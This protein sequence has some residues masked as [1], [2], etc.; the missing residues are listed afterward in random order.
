MTAR[1]QYGNLMLRKR[2]KGPD[3]W[4]FRWMEN[5]K[6]KS[7]LIGTIE[8]YPTRADAERAI[9]YLRIK[10]NAQSAQSEFH[11]VTVGGLLD[12]Y[13]E[14]EMPARAYSTAQTYRMYINRYV[15]PVWGAVTLDKIKPVPVEHWLRSLTSLSDRS[16][17][18]IRNIFHLVFQCALRWELAQTNPI[19]LVRQGGK[20]R[21]TP[22]VLTP[23]E[24]GTLLARLAAPYNSMVLFCAGLGLRISEVMGLKWGDVDWE[25]LSVK[26]RR[27]IVA[28]RETPLKTE[29]SRKPLPLDPDL[30]TE[31]L[32][33]RAKTNH[34]SASDF[35]Y[36]G[37]SGR[38]RWQGMIL[39]DYIQPAVNKA[40][41]GKIGWHTFRHT[42]STLLHAR[43]T[44][45]AV[46]KELLRHADI[47]TTMNVYTQ[48]VSDDKRQAVS[49]V[50]DTLLNRKRRVVRT[51]TR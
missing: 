1:Y 41:I 45:L 19:S 5:G 40:G 4:Q 29:A 46:Q 12:R 42:F 17:Q 21:D 26:V 32:S 22:R 3:V 25:H 49:A 43:G 39:K 34:T 14:E 47:S 10:I 28:G 44:P 36:A 15:R 50:M 2:K 35:V 38:P 23:R 33:W 9:E 27:G 30:A 20:R 51:C 16:K 18:A 13:M 11:A 48:A 8:K 7:M 31:L 37:V 6:P 24:F